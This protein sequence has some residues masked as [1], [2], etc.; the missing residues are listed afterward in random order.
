MFPIPK[1]SIFSPIAKP[2]F[3]PTC[4]RAAPL[5]AARFLHL[6][7]VRSH[8]AR[9]CLLPP[10]ALKV[11]TPLNLAAW[12]SAL[13]NH[14]N[15]LWVNSLL[16]GLQEGVRIGFNPAA[17]CRSASSNM[18]SA[19]AHPDVV[20]KYLTDELQAGNLAGPF[21]PS[22]V[23]EAVINR[24]G[25]I[26]KPHK[27]GKWRLIVDLSYPP[28]GSVND[29]ISTMDSSMVYSSLDDAAHLIASLGRNSCL[30][31]IDIC[32]A[33]RIIPVHPQDRS[34][35]CMRWGEGIYVDSQLPFGLRSAPLIFNAYADALEW[36]L[37][38]HGC[39]HII[40][41]LDDFLVLGPSNSAVCQTALRTML[42]TCSS[43]GV[44]L[45]EEK[46]EGPSTCLSFLGI[47]LDTSTMQARLPQDKLVRL[48]QELALW[49]DKKSC[50]RKELEH[51]I[52]VLQFACK[53]IPQGRPFVRRL[54]NL[55]CVPCK[56]FHHVRL[57]KA[58][59]SDLLWWHSF[60]HIWNGI[61]LL[62][63]SDGLIPSVNVFTD[64][65]GSFGCGAVWGLKW[66]QGV[67]PADWLHVNIMVKEL[68]PV[69]LACAI[70]AH[71]WSGQHIH[72]HVDNRAVVEVLK[73]GSSKEPSGIV[74]HLLRCLSFISAYF[75]FTYTAYHIPGAYNTT[76]DSISRN[77][78]SSIPPQ[79][80][81]ISADLWSLLV[82]VR[83][84]WT[85]KEWRVRFTNFIRTV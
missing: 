6:Q 49:Q 37:R 83:P 76:A 4:T 22:Q 52:G 44:P 39:H 60:A 31:K 2:S 35:L 82:L 79:K 78:L 19:T 40:H 59:R 55:L 36:I 61:S 38:D 84:D 25:V 70:W 8:S 73:K 34:L 46:I 41:Y 50:T 27:P 53:V 56:P 85:S 51:L 10:S 74:M 66:L 9:P 21:S 72:L 17:L 58:S 69:V 33:F 77:R 43:L 18:Q 65:S 11:H 67:W 57:N 14:P 71:Q 26:P 7:Q 29:G 15:R 5:L 16:T 63:L 64:A 75:Q 13:R 45:A 28:G 54:I 12:S 47:E 42:S 24:F 62:R 80:C 3:Q 68:V 48:V 1:V 30:A 81:I 23:R 20:Q 32:S